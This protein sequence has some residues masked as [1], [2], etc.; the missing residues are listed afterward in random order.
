MLTGTPFPFGYVDKTTELR[1]CQP[2]IGLSLRGRVREVR[3]N[4][5][6]Q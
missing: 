3:R 1:A 2:L 5:R 4:N 6:D